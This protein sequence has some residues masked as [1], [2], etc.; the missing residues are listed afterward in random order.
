MLVA[1]AATVTII[2]VLAAQYVVTL[3]APGFL[4]DAA[5][6]AEGDIAVD[7]FRLAVDAGSAAQ[8][9]AA[10]TAVTIGDGEA[11]QLDI[12]AP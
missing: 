11:V 12:V 9:V 2:G 6:V 10:G 7:R 3:I 5:L 4:D 1:I 8:V